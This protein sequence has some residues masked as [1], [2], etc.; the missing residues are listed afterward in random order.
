MA[1]PVYAFSLTPEGLIRLNEVSNFQDLPWSE[2]FG[3]FAAGYLAYLD[4]RF[5]FIT[6]PEQST[7]FTQRLQHVGLFYW[8][9]LPLILIGLWQ[10]LTSKQKDQYFWLVWLLLAPLGINLHIHTKPA[11]WLTA[12]PVLHGLAGAGF[13][14]LWQARSRG[15]LASQ[16]L[17]LRFQ[18]SL[19]NLSLIVIAVLAVLNIRTMVVD[20]F[21][22]FPRYA[23]YTIDWGYQ[24]EQ[25]IRDLVELSPAFDSTNLDTFEIVSGL[26]YAYY[27]RFPPR[28]RHAEVAQFGEA[29]WRRVGPTL[30]GPLDSFAL[31]P[32]CH[33]TLSRIEQRV[34][35]PLPWLLLKTYPFP[36]GEP[37]Q[38]GISAVLLPRSEGRPVQAIFGEQIMLHSYTLALDQTEDG[39]LEMEPGQALCLMLNWQSAGDLRSDYTAFVHLNGPPNPATNS[40][41]WVQH[42]GIP[43]AGRRPTTSWQPGEIVND[44]HVFIIPADIA[45]GRY[46]IDVGLYDSHSGNNLE[47]NQQAR[48]TLFEIVIP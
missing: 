6:R 26:Y 44:M 37:A 18:R 3:P 36:D 46:Q 33:L 12:T 24:M 38:V 14:W 31:E 20:L 7:L 27:T 15:F 1:Y 39:P 16:R 47:V 5:L 28:A 23:P 48:L 30:V 10:S 13:A 25:G 43:A 41:L 4:P 34:G 2:R 11:L 35:S 29:A 42:D 40:P 19:I 45:S 17:T 22:E 9:E 21:T 8:F 32:G